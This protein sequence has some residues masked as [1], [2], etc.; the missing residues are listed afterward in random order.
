M[1]ASKTFTVKYRR[2]KEEKT[3]YRKRLKLLKSE[4]VRIVLRVSNKNIFIQGIE[5]NEKGDKIIAQTNSIELKKYGWNVPTSNIPSSYLTGL[6]F[7]KKFKSKI[8]EAI[9][10]LGMKK[11]AYRSRLAAGIKG[12]SDGGIKINYNE[13]I[14]PTQ[15]DIEGKT[16]AKFAQELSNDQNKYKKQFSIYL[17][18][19]IKPE[20]LPEIFS[21]IKQKL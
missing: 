6:L 11:L 9:I 7:S 21:N 3:D 5:F 10:D 14:S 1:A 2:K 8:K 16:I 17:K 20:E 19:N 15:E 13:K 12:I 18:N 4:K